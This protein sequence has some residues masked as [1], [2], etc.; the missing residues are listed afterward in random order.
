V[1]VPLSIGGKIV[2]EATEFL[3]IL[4][5]EAGEKLLGSHAL[6]KL[7]GRQPRE[8]L[9]GSQPLKAF[10]DGGVLDDELLGVAEECFPIDWHG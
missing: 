10:L 3:A 9:L 1:R 6:K 2:E 7:S 8:K 4:K 5:G